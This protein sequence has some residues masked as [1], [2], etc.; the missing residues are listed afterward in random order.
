MKKYALI[1]AGGSGKRMKTD[2]PKQFLEL[3]G[4][5][6]LMYTLEKFI[7]ADSKISLILVLPKVYHKHWELLCIQ[8]NFHHFHQIVAGGESRFQSVKN[9]LFACNKQ[10]LIAIHDGVRPL[11]STILILNLYRLAQEKK[12]AIPVLPLV[13][14]IRNIVKAES[15]AVDRRDFVSVQTPQCFS[16]ELINRAYSQEEKPYFTDDASVIDA[17]GEKVYFI[18]GESE[19]IK[20]TRPTDLIIAQHLLNEC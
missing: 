2:I 14:S 20:I 8:H 4:R 13:E 11:V 10:G 15:R 9:G 19:N 16:L 6:I 5:P 12:S 3:N 7:S 17:L 1:V 18:Q